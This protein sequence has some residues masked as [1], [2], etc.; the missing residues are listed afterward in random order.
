MR[1]ISVKIIILRNGPALTLASVGKCKTN[2]SFPS[3]IE[4]IFWTWKSNLCRFE[5]SNSNVLAAKNSPKTVEATNTKTKTFLPYHP[6][7]M[8]KVL[9]FFYKNWPFPASFLSL[10]SAFQQLTVNMFIIRF[11]R[12]L[13]SN[14]RPLASEA[15]ALPTEP[16]PFR[17]IILDHWVRIF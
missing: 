1:L 16:Q 17:I 8:M 2:F 3:K 15:T 14:C 12:W 10:F 11:C 4:I 5:A 6:S 7:P 13:D 9:N